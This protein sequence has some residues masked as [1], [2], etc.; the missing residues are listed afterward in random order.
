MP[1][2][3]ANPIREGGI[4]PER[5]NPVVWRAA[6]KSRSRTI[7]LRLASTGGAGEGVEEPRAARVHRRLSQGG[8]ER[9]T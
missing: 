5:A 6:L 8:R 3:R 9:G 4:C 2:E 7:T 1:G